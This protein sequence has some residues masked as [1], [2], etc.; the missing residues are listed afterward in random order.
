[1]FYLYTKTEDRQTIV[2]ILKSLDWGQSV[3]TGIMK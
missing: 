1:M 2:N 3:F